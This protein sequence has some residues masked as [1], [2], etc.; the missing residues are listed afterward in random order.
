MDGPALQLGFGPIRHTRLR[1][2]RHAFGYPGVFLR[3]RVDG[4]AARRE[5]ARLG[6]WFGWDAAAP[7]SFRS[8]DHGDGRTPLADWARELCA[9]VGVRADGAIWLHTFPR[10][11]GYAFKPASFWCGHRADGA[12]V[13]A[14]AEV[15]STFGGRHCYRLAAP[16]GGPLP[17]G[18]E[19]RARKVFHVSPFCSVEGEYTFRFFNRADRALARIDYHDAQGP[20]LLTSL[21]GELVPADRAA[22]RRALFGQPLFTLGVIGRIHWHALKLWLA[23]VPFHRKP[24]PPEAFVSRGHR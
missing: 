2:G 23:R 8:A 24:E 5:A 17:Q 15:N 9:Q 11:L 19:L 1:P 13:A 12:L 7:V 4:E 22:V 6:R 3:M 16:D 18:R 14:V 21:S 20:L 10:M